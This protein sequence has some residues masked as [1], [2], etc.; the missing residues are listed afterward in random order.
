MF[1]LKYA[2]VH[3]LNDVER[4]KKKDLSCVIDLSVKFF[5]G[6][7]LKVRINTNDQK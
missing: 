3:T 5:G 7:A 4:E 6:S 2:E 1:L